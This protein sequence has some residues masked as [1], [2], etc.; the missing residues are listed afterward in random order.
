[1]QRAMNEIQPTLI[2]LFHSY[3][4]LRTEIMAKH[5]RQYSNYIMSKWEQLP[6]CEGSFLH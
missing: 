3:F 6:I 4:Y 5:S 1:M 2:F